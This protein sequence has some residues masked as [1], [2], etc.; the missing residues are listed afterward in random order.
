[1]EI[2]SRL[3]REQ[4]QGYQMTYL[5]TAETALK[6]QGCKWEDLKAVNE[7]V[8]VRKMRNANIES[9]GMKNGRQFSGKLLTLLCP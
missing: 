7:R 9:A 5:E 6:P 3:W 1:M 8:L 4:P 2:N